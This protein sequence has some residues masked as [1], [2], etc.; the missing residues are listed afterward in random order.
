MNRFK[1]KHNWEIA[2]DYQRTRQGELSSVLR[3][4]KCKVNMA[5]NEVADMELWKHTVGVQKWLSIG[6]FLIAIA[7]LII[8]FLK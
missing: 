1:C 2:R 4:K 8:S 7:S 3:C 5:A 6:A